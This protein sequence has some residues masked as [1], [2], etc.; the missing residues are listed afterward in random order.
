[1]KKIRFGIGGA[2]ASVL[3]AG[4]FCGDGDDDTNP[5][6]TTQP[7]EA[8]LVGDWTYRLEG[9]FIPTPLDIVLS[10]AE[11]KAYEV[12]VAEVEDDTLVVHRGAWDT[13][14]DQV[15]LVG[16][17]CR[18]IDTTAHPDTLRPMPAA[19][20]GQPM[21]LTGPQSTTW[22]IST[23]ELMPLLSQLAID[24]SLLSRIPYIPVE[25]NEP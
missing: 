20:C 25:K 6:G 16:D 9:M 22:R 8:L 2:M 1:M 13:T 21:Q 18:M 14:G 5:A 23:S 10:F 24:T 7:Q 19:L 11:S 17:D 3:L 15:T 4:L 12:S